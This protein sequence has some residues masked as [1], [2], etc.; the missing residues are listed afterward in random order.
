MPHRPRN[1]FSLFFSA[2]LNISCKLLGDLTTV[3]WYKHLVKYTCVPN[4]PLLT[5]RRHLAGGQLAWPPRSEPRLRLS[6]PP[7]QSASPAGDCSGLCHI[8]RPLPGER[9]SPSEGRQQHI[10]RSIASIHL[11]GDIFLYSRHQFS[12]PNK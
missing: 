1:C 3:K 5:G 12:L 9:R 7:S 2:I 6:R 4:L 10:L 11:Q 8:P